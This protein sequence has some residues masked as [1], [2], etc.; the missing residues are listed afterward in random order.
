MGCGGAQTWGLGGTDDRGTPHYTQIFAAAG[1][2]H[3]GFLNAQTSHSQ[4]PDL[5]SGSSVPEVG[6]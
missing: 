1:L 4:L 6:T 5:I 2:S 3:G